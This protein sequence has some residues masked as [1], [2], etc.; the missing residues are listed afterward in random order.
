MTPSTGRRALDL[1]EH[2]HTITAVAAQTGMPAGLVRKLGAAIGLVEHPD[3]TMRYTPPHGPAPAGR[4]E[5][6]RARDAAANYPA[7]QVRAWAREHGI[8]CPDRGRY[9]PPDV[10]AAWRAANP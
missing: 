10:V 2:G 3:G 7:A 1:L 8:P 6:G 4:A 9:L 5:G